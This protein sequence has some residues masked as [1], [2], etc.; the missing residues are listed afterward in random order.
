MLKV[1]SGLFA[2]ASV[3]AAQLPA[4][5]PEL[6]QGWLRMYDLRF[7]EAHAVFGE[8]KRAR[9]LDPMGPVSDAAAFLFSELARL[10]ILEAE[11]FTDNSRFLNREKPKPDLKMKSSFLREILSA[12]KQADT[13]LSKS[14]GDANALLAKSL[15]FGLRADFSSLIEKQDLTA[16][17]LTKEGRVW[18][19]RLTVVDPKNFD[20]WLGL[21]VENYLL[22]L[23]PAPLR[24]VLWLTGAKVD[25][26]KG[27]AQ[28][29]RTA[30]GGHYL[31]PFAKLLLAVAAIRDRNPDEARR[32]L[33]EL[34]TRFP[35]NELYLR[36]LNRIGGAP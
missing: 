28:L 18:A 8:W 27:I 31:E 21:G 32:L 25:H 20:A 24:A 22:S 29:R 14:S 23:K 11:F 34:H 13:A 9:P 16:L 19:D 10:G 17:R 26:D 12:E 5:P 33:A 3:S 35:N 15:T 30:E 6:Y 1:L 4:G 2:V 7:D 36:E